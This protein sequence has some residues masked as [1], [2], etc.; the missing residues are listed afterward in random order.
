[1][2]LDSRTRIRGEQ[3]KRNLLE[4]FKQKTTHFLSLKL[5]ILLQHF[6]TKFVIVLQVATFFKLIKI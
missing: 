1:M 3:K 5:N 2:L 6:I 4:V